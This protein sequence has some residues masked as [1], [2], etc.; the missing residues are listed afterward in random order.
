M[1]PS[2]ATRLAPQAGAV[3]PS[4]AIASTTRRVPQRCSAIGRRAD[5]L[6]ENVALQLQQSGGELATQRPPRVERDGSIFRVLVGAV[7]DRAAAQSLAQQLE[8]LLGRE[9]TLFMR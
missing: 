6:R 7:A 3:A 2:T 8:R 5:A 1:S 4:T 9:T